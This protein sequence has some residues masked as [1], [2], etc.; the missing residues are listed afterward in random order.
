MSEASLYRILARTQRAARRHTGPRA[1]LSLSLCTLGA[2]WA[3]SAISGG[4][5]KGM[6]ATLLGERW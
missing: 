2:H 1:S 6:S 3:T 4:M 5:Q